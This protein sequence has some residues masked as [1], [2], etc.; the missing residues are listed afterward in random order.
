MSSLHLSLLSILLTTILAE[1]TTL[2]FTQPSYDLWCEENLLSN[3]LF[4]Y[5]SPVPLG[6]P[7]T[8]SIKS[9]TYQLLDDDSNGLFQ[10]KARRVADFYFL[11]FNL[12]RPFDINREYQDV[13]RLRVQATLLT[14]QENQTEQ[15][16]VST[17]LLS[18]A[19]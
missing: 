14:A 7:R 10:V 2:F 17:S 15:V 9:V 18:R 6:I 3:G 16:E 11:I 5:P 12:T 1:N 19:L 4:L 8:S 13:Y